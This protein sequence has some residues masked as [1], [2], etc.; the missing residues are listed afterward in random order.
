MERS[1]SIVMANTNGTLR[2]WSYTPAVSTQRSFL[3]TPGAEGVAQATVFIMVGR[4]PD[5]GGVV[6]RTW[7]V[8]GAPDYLA[9]QY[10]GARCGVSPLTNVIVA[11]SFIPGT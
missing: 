11:A 8:T 5:C 3:L 10:T 9:T 6:Y 7:Q 2:A 4:D 1:G